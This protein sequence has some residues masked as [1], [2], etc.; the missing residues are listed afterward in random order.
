MKNK[1]DRKIV[2]SISLD[3]ELL[4]VVNNTISNRS[5]F[6]ENCIISELCK[7]LEIRDI[8]KNKKIIL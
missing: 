4:D 2:I 1:I 3:A 7:S 8:L 6:F 5:K